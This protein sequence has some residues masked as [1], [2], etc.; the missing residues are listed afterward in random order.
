MASGTTSAFRAARIDSLRFGLCAPLDAAPLGS[1]LG[2][3]RED[4]KESMGTRGPAG[5]C[6]G[7]AAH[8]PRGPGTSR[9]WSLAAPGFSNLGPMSTASPAPVPELSLAV[10]REWFPVFNRWAYLDFAGVAPIPQIAVDAATLALEA[11]ALGAI[12]SVDDTEAAIEELREDVARFVGATAEEI[13]FVRNTT[14]GLGWVANGLGLGAGTGWWSPV[15]TSRARCC[16]GPTSPPAASTSTSWPAAGPVSSSTTS[17]RPSAAGSHRRSSRSRGSTTRP[18][19]G[20]TSAR[21]CVHVT[22]VVRSCAQM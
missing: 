1:R 14:E 17:S 15:T 12:V 10:A 2:R 22:S 13:A 16:P 5:R 11:Q 21:S 9:R 3:V 8:G 6:R 18:D 4:P 19:G 7:G 20:P